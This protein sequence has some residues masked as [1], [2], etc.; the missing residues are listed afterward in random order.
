MITIAADSSVYMKRA[1]AEA[2]GVRII[3]LTY[4]AGGLPYSESYGDEN[5][6]YEALLK[7]PEQ[8]TT[9]Q[10]SMASF[11]SCFEEEL[12][13][14]RQVLCVTISSRLSGAFGTAYLAAQHVKSDNIA[15]FDSYL[16]AGGLFL[17]V[18]EAAGLIAGGAKLHDLLLKL[19]SVRD[20]ISI[21]FSVD[22]IEP[23]RASGRAGFVRMSVGT[24]LDIKPILICREGAVVY[25]SSARGSGGV[26]KK[27]I[28]KIPDGAVEAVINY[29]GDNR[30][31]TNLYNVITSARPKLSVKLQKIGPVLGIN[32]GLKAL[33]VSV[34]TR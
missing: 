15:V 3:P 25:E 31:A 14:G 6:D 1:E 33:G 4:T 17:L 11:I 18:K 23:L 26:I 30:V 27:M 32:L 9:S 5:G 12:A 22:S 24:I 10:P 21:T 7:K 19:P 13:K 34:L 16:T 28:Q 8:F 29:I 2:L 20:K